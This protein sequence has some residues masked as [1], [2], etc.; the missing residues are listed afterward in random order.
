MY[1]T[2]KQLLGGSCIKIVITVRYRLAERRQTIRP[3]GRPFGLIFPD[4]APKRGCCRYRVKKRVKLSNSP[5]LSKSAAAAGSHH[6][7][8]IAAYLPRKF[9]L[10]T[11]EQRIGQ[12]METGRMVLMARMAKFVDNHIFDERQR[13]THEEDAE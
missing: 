4:T 3:G 8:Y 9:L 7:R 12:R 5:L 10:P 11:A 6:I 2:E 13:Q 1:H